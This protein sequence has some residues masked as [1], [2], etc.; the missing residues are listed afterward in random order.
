MI[1]DPLAEQRQINRLA[2]SIAKL[3]KKEDR[4]AA[5]EKVPE[6]LRPRVK[7]AATDM[8]EKRKAE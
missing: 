8:I 3:P 1:N 4:V 6:I 5:L 2:A 7:E